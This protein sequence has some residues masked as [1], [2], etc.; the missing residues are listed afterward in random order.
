MISLIYNELIT[1]LFGTNIPT[2]L[3]PISQEVCALLSIFLFCVIISLPIYIIYKFALA[4]WNGGKL[5]K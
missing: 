5:F 3:E 4:V 1:N 2:I